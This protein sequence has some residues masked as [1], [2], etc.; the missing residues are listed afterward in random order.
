MNLNKTSTDHAEIKDWVI[1][2]K[3]HPQIIEIPDAN[4]KV[5]IRIDFP[6]EFDEKY[7]VTEY[8]SDSTW[9]QF[10]KIF[11]EQSL[12]FIYSDEEKIV[13]PSAAYKFIKRNMV[14]S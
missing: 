8:S 2:H 11:D 14:N 4:D 7:A 13:D 9:G 10:F 1:K 6:G 5:G 3:G 12:A